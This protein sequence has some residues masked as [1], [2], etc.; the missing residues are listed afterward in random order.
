MYHTQSIKFIFL[1]WNLFLACIPL[2]LSKYLIYSKT[3]RFLVVWWCVAT[4][5]VFFPN[6][7]Y[8]LTDLRHITISS[9]STFWFDLLLILSFS[10]VGLFAGLMSLRDIEQLLLSKYKSLYVNVLIAFMLFLSAFGVYLGRFLRWNSWDIVSAPQGLLQDI[11]SRVLHPG[12][13]M[14]TWMITLLLGVFLNMVY[15]SFKT[16]RFAQGSKI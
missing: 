3:K 1:V 14:N 16:L 10:W 6:A 4:W 8:I 13:H 5:V 11:V 12:Q 15:Q 7:P 9:D 2:V